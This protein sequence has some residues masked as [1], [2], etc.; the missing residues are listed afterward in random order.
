MGDEVLAEGIGGIIPHREVA[1]FPQQ[2]QQERS[3]IQNRELAMRVLKSRLYERYLE[4][5][6][7][8]SRN[9]AEVSSRC[10]PEWRP[11]LLTAIISFSH[12]IV[13]V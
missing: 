1:L 2:S 13:T 9:M 3:Q 4:K 8:Y 6:R 12:L 5:Q 11:S 7:L 10:H